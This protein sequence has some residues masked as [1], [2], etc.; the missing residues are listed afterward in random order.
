MQESISLV[1]FALW[2]YIIP[3]FLIYLAVLGFVFVAFVL[4][5]LVFFVLGTIQGWVVST[6]Y[7]PF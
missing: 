3:F 5:E 2:Q 4:A 6:L 7:R 1:M